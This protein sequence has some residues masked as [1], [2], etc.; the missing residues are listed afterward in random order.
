VNKVFGLVGWDSDPSKGIVN[1]FIPVDPLGRIRTYGVIVSAFFS[2]W[3]KRAEL[4]ALTPLRVECDGIY[5]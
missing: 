3:R 1:T 5:L 4:E 2:R